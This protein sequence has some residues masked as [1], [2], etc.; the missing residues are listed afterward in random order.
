VMTL[1]APTL[2]RQVTP[3]VAVPRSKWIGE[4]AEGRLGKS[5]NFALGDIGCVDCG[6]VASL[7]DCLP[8][9]FLK[10]IAPEVV[11]EVEGVR[12]IENRIEITSPARHEAA[13]PEARNH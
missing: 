5:G 9:D 6:G 12:E 11:A 10:R 3:L 8:T 1:D 13:G 4:L 7:R 2:E